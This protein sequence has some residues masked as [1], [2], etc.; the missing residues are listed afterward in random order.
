MKHGERIAPLRPASLPCQ[1]SCAAFLLDSLAAAMTATASIVIG[2]MRMWFLVL[3]WSSSFL[4]SSN[5]IAHARAV[6]RTAPA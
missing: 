5:C 4:V 2:K 1:R 3:L 6:D